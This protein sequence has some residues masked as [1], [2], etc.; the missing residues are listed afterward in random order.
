MCRSVPQIAV[1]STLISTSFGPATGTGTC[2]IHRP[3]AVSRLTSAFM[4]ADI[5]G[6]PAGTGGH[7]RLQRKPRARGN[8]AGQRRGG[9]LQSAGH[10][11]W[12][13]SMR[14][15]LPCLS[16]AIALSIAPAAGAVEGMWVPQQLPEI[17]APLKQAGLKLDPAQLAD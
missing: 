17:S 8:R 14:L 4:V 12:N 9:R 5:V 1:F 10:F 15:S 11:R 16:V 2:S 13:R 6:R 7:Y 3:L